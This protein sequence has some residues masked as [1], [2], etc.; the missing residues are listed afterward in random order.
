MLFIQSSILVSDI[1][2]NMSETD[3]VITNLI[4][5]KET[6][7]T[8][9]SFIDQAEDFILMMKYKLEI[10]NLARCFTGLK[11]TN[12]FFGKRVY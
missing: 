6:K 12:S 10:T 1:D 5:N 9:F 11:R 8:F 4:E 3:I 2:A 7:N